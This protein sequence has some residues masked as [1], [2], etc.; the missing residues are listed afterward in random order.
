MIDII[1]IIIFSIAFIYGLIRGFLA[2]ISPFIALVASVFLSPIVN[3]L[4]LI[5]TNF[6]RE[7]IIIKIVI[8]LLIYALFR[9]IMSKL[10]DSMKELLKFAYLNWVDS[11]TGGI[12]AL[13]ISVIIVIMIVSLITEF[14]GITL[15]SKVLTFLM[16][17]YVFIIN[18]VNDILY[19]LFKR[20]KKDLLFED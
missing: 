1:L 16:E 13:A 19:H 8:F 11:I 3:T 20:A 14:T 15:N 2:I 12:S 17:K 5:H 9:I 7:N 18:N 4:L 6:Y 10:R